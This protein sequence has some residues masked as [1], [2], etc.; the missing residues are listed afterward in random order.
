MGSSSPYNLVSCAS[1]SG[2]SIPPGAIGTPAYCP[3]CENGWAWNAGYEQCQRATSSGSEY[4][5]PTTVNCSATNTCYPGTGCNPPSSSI[6]GSS[7]SQVKCDNNETGI[8]TAIGCIHVLDSTDA[9]LGD[10]LRWGVGV[11]SGIAFMLSLYAG[12]MVMTSA[13]NPERL[14]A[15][16]ELL[17]SAIG[18]LILLIFS[19]FI[20]KFIGIDIL[21]LCN[22]GFGGPCQ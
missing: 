15:G 20:L 12:F 10:L 4:K 11:G 5:D 1:S 19:V 9:F 3:V 2:P 6:G 13:G 7:A 18:G 22:L 16:Q 14:K 8:Q 21:K 17:T